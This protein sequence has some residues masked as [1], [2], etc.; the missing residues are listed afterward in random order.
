MTDIIIK[1]DEKEQEKKVEP[2]EIKEVLK[3]ADE[4]EKKKE[5]VEKLE[6]LYQREQEIKAK[7]ALGGK[8]DAGQPGKTQEELDEEEAARRLAAF[9]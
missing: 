5:E 2:E 6:A 3:E 1:Q 8:A 4:Y 9:T 7:M